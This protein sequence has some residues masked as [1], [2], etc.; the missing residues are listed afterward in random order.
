M[1]SRGAVQMENIGKRPVCPPDC[2]PIHGKIQGVPGK[3]GRLIG[4]RAVPNA[5]DYECTAGK[6]LVFCGRVRFNFC[7][8]EILDASLACW[9]LL[10]HIGE[11]TLIF[12][13]VGE[14]YV[15]LFLHK[16]ERETAARR[17]NVVFT[18]LL[19]VGV[20]IETIA[21][22]RADDIV[23]QMRAP[24][25]LS[26]IRQAAIAEKLKSFGMHEAVFFEVSDVDPEVAGIA[27]DLSR[28][29]ASAGWKSGFESWPPK[30]PR[31]LEQ[32]ARGILLVVSPAAPDKTVLPA[33]QMLTSMLR[34][35]GFQ[36]ELSQSFVGPNPPADN[37]IKI[38][39]YTK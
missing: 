37:R 30:L 1:R 10:R 20:G 9:L 2:P 4:W 15:L 39:V 33:A 13:L 14:L 32:P 8:Q 26:R 11:C 3:I 29:C 24:R 17:L 18:A 22:A 27:A 34:D 28:A 31:E 7:V 5:I 19:I 23:R 38:A 6:A 25:S 12:G 16:P 35:D 36:V 21:G